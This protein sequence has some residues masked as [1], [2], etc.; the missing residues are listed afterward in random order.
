MILLGD[1]QLKETMP[2][3]LIHVIM[4]L[5]FIVRKYLLGCTL[6]KLF[7][8]WNQEVLYSFYCRLHVKTETYHYLYFK[9]QSPKILGMCFWKFE[10]GNWILKSVKSPTKI[11]YPLRVLHL[12][13][14]NASFSGI[15]EFIYSFTV[16]ITY[17][18]TYER[19]L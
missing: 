2:F 1:N 8:D 18:S 17:N 7:Y 4:K 12:H 13:T 15:V 3:I 5:C 10:N 9:E 16:F 6:H 19:S 11:E 14:T